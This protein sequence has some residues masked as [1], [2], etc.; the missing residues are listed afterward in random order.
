MKIRSL[1]I[2]GAVLAV[3]GGLPP[4]ASLFPR[5]DAPNVPN[6]PYF[7]QAPPGDTPILFAPGIVSTGAND[8]SI[9]F[10][11]DPMEIFV[12]RSSPD[13][14]TSIVMLQRTEVGWAPPRMAP[15][16]KGF[17][18]VYPFYSGTEGAVFFNSTR[19]LPEGRAG[20]PVRAVWVARR[21]GRD[22]SEPALLSDKLDPSLQMGHPSVSKNGN[23][24]FFSF[25][26][27]RGADASDLFVLEKKDGRY[28]QIRNLGPAVNSEYPEFHPFIS[29]D[30]DYL[31]FDSRRPDGLG[32]NDLYISFRQPDGTWTKAVNMGEPINSGSS[33]MRACVSP[34][35]K[36]LF[37]SSMRTNPRVDVSGRNPDYEAFSK[38]VFGPGNG[39][40][41]IYWMSA[42]I[43]QKLKNRVLSKRP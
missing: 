42:S 22:W 4:A 26:S 24:Y 10:S 37:F 41:D 25:D 9:A 34:D 33:D 12:S 15:F 7:G 32:G 13:W 27:N 18:D 23:V 40:Q 1:V 29:P 20:I 28:G 2:H 38:I 21:A 14:T 11:I 39:S 6:L 16:I 35:G 19:S 36:Y 31:I 3:I 5:Q 17:G 8:M 30:E 43:I